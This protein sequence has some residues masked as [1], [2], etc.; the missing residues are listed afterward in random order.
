MNRI[1]FATVDR[2]RLKEF[3]GAMAAG[4][5]VEIAWADSGAAALAD[6]MTQPPLAVIVDATLPDMDGLELVRRLLPINA[7]IYTAVISDLPAERFHEA[8]EGLGVLAQLPPQP[9]PAQATELLG[10]LKRLSRGFTLSTGTTPTLPQT[11]GSH[12]P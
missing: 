6:V 10:R 12:R 7:M 4:G 1:L 8:S 2:A 9:T 11:G 5:E 3:A